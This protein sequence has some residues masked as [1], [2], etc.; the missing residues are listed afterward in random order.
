MK[1]EDRV[2]EIIKQRGRYLIR[3]GSGDSFVIPRAVLRLHPLEVG[4][5]LDVDAY[6]LSLLKD[7]RRLALERAGRMLGQR[8]YSSGGLYEK[9]SAVGYQHESVAKAIAFLMERGYLDDERYAR[10]LLERKKKRSG[11]LLIR[12]DMKLKGLSERHAQQALEELS[13][14]EQQQHAVALLGKYVRGKDEEPRALYQKALAFLG[15]RGFAYD[16]ARSAVQQ[17]IYPPDDDFSDG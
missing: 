4:Q 17:V 9:L 1:A 16:V 14:Q 5:P 12:R 8:D 2:L 6:R 15:R 13:D 11:A 7:E 3:L 10:Q